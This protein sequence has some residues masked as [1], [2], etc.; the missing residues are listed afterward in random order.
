MLLA[1]K[2][3][4]LPGAVTEVPIRRSESDILVQPPRFCKHFFTS[5]RRYPGLSRQWRAR[6]ESNL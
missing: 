2:L 5:G 1:L 4:T 3:E 6:Q